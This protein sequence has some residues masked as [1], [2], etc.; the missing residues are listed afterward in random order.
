MT[1]SRMKQL[2]AKGEGFT[3][4]YKTCDNKIS[5]S[6]YET[7]CS[8]SNRYGG[9][10]ILGTDDN[11]NVIGIDRTASKQMRKD[12]ANT[13]HNPQ[14]MSP[15]LYLS[16]EEI[17]IDGKLLLYAYVPPSAQVQSC[18]GKIFDRNVDGDQ[19]ITKFVDRVAQITLRKQATHTERE[20]FPYV[21]DNEIRFELVEK[22][23]KMAVAHN[24]EHPWRNMTPKEILRSA[25]LI[26]TDF[27]TG[28]TGYNLASILL[29]GHDDVIRSCAPGYMTDAIRRVDNLD[30]YDDRLMVGTNLIE[31]YEQLMDFIS[32]HTLDRFFL[33]DNQRVSVRSWIARELVSNIL[34]HREFSRGY[35][36]RIIIEK[37][38][39]FAENWNKPT[40]P[41]RLTLESFKPEPKN[42]LLAQFFIQIGRA[43]ILGSGVRNLYKYTHI[44]SGS[45]PQLIEDDIFT[46]I[47]P[48][49]SESHGK[50]EEVREEVTAEVREEVRL[51]QEKLSTLL[52][53]CTTPKS[54]KEMQ[55]FCE[56][57]SDEHFRAKVIKPML[58]L[59]LIKM[60]IPDKP[61]S[62][63]QKYIKL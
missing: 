25:G 24:S 16:L 3:V 61:N 34:V 5:A 14:K 42:P 63:S 23:K 39:I 26:E 29:F 22:A 1:I 59:G 9:H 46:T 60:T 54:K 31:A 43:D 52:Q 44:Y 2:L 37:D 12:F 49:K 8:F 11:G 47:I 18:N 58:K 7:V 13:L 38:R 35:M 51:T 19:D 55:A 17:E 32:K 36:A 20:V 6:V 27:R 28:H 45:E 53:Y 15:S 10:L 41:G 62:R 57:K 40:R 56:V 30:R 21:T 4:E 50:I 48:L 33:V